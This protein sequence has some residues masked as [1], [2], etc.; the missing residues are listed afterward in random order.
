MCQSIYSRRKADNIQSPNAAGAMTTRVPYKDTWPSDDKDANF[1]TDVALD[2]K[3]DP[4][5]TVVRPSQ[6]TRV[7]PGAAR[8][9]CAAVL[10]SGASGVYE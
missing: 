2:G 9:S 8:A 6:A 7:P 3:F 1:K 5:K 4:L 10:K